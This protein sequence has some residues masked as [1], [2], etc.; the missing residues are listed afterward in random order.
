MLGRL[1]DKVKFTGVWLDMNEYANFCDGACEIPSS[2]SKFDYSKDLPYQ[3]GGDGIESHTISLNSTH[4]GNLS[5]ADVHAF[6]AFLETEST[7]AFLK[8]KNLRPF[9]ISR[10]S[11]FGSNKFGFHWTGDNYASW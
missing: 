11:T 3:P 1:Y 4:Y 6:S 8:S 10:S 7:N 5:E 2:P 9:I